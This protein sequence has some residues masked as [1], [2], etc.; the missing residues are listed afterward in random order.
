[1]KP[2]VKP[3]ETT[4]EQLQHIATIDLSGVAAR[5][6]KDPQGRQCVSLRLGN[7]DVCF[8]VQQAL[9]VREILDASIRAMTHFTHIIEPEHKAGTELA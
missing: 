7:H 1:M 8:T 3:V 5:I 6:V 2:D 9:L 4:E